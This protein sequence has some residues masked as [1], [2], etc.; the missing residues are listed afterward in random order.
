MDPSASNW[1]PFSVP[2]SE[3]YLRALSNEVDRRPKSS[4]NLCLFRHN[5]EMNAPQSF[6]KIVVPSLVVIVP[7]G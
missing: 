4:S 7:I 3:R 6:Q 1:P 5:M 2:F